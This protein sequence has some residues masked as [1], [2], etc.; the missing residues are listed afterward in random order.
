MYED[1]TATALLV[2]VLCSAFWW[3]GPTQWALRGGTVEFTILGRVGQVIFFII[4]AAVL[5]V[6][7]VCAGGLWTARFFKRTNATLNS[8]AAFL[9]RDEEARLGE[10]RERSLPLWLCYVASCCGCCGLSGL[11]TPRREGEPGW[12]DYF[13]AAMRVLTCWLVPRYYEGEPPTT[14]SWYLRD[15]ASWLACRGCGLF[16]ACR[17]QPEQYAPTASERA[18]V[19]ERERLQGGWQGKSTAQIQ[20]VMRAHVEAEAARGRARVWRTL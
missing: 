8:L 10:R 7:F 9:K 18:A 16:T 3:D 19:E 6:C 20:A 12:R 2:A 17:K 5:G 13:N 14:W 15:W 11:C 1:D 4:M